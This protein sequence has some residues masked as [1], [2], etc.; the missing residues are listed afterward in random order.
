MSK[1]AKAKKTTS[2]KRV[3]IHAEVAPAQTPKTEAPA[4]KTNEAPPAATKTDGKMSGLDAAA[5]VLEGSG[6]LNAK[7]M[8]EFM[9]A[10]GLWTSNGKT[11][12]STIYA[13]IIREIALKGPQ[14]RFRKAER[15]RFTLAS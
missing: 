11:P 15:G 5:K 9:V 2:T 4:V 1:K 6:P 10:R 13:A 3:K 8:V 12:H 7:E 14:A